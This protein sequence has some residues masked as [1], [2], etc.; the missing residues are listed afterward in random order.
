MQAAETQEVEQSLTDSTPLY[1]DENIPLKKRLQ[2]KKLLN[3]LR[4]KEGGFI[5]SKITFGDHYDFVSIL[6]K[7]A[8][9]HVLR[10]KKKDPE[11]EEVAIKIIAKNEL[12]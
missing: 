10:V 1:Y 11:G 8:F 4:I 2:E 3:R 7:G 9:G 5:D 6:G 12:K